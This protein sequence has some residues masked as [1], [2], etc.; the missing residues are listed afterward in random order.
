MTVKNT[1]RKIA[2]ESAEYPEALRHI[3][4]APEELF[5]DGKIV[6]SD[7]N[8][9]AIVGTRR[10]TEYGSKQCERLSFDL[11]VRGITVVS[12]MALGIDTAAHRGAIRAGGRTIAVMGSGHSNIY[13]P[14]NRDLYDE[15]VKNGAVVSEFPPETFPLKMNFPKRNRIISGMSKGVVVIE[16]P[17]RSGALI[18][19]NFALEQGREV[20]AMPG[21]VSS[22]KSTGTNRLI[23]AG[24]RLVEDVN[25]VLEELR[26]VMKAEEI[27]GDQKG[28]VF[29]K[30]DIG[31]SM[32]ANEAKIF[33][34]LGD[35]PKSIDEI[36][37]VIE[38]PVNKVSEI[39]LR[40]ELKKL[41]R[42]LPG[43][44]FTKVP[45]V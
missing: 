30:P 35:I 44:N 24:A 10:A 26:Y 33:E 12:G 42:A 28:P 19:A 29:L 15:I 3:Y 21:N 5:I 2:R 9:V 1:V 36:S 27:K 40:L 13:P 34:V 37:K 23:K 31:R 7:S 18:T 32:S 11:A 6:S 14:E 16:A 45:Y 8:A 22:A 20:F 43:E 41:I 4:N 17:E 39:L 25:D 38:I